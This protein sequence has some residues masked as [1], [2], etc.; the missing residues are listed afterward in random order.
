MT[1]TRASFVSTLF[2][3]S[4]SAFGADPKP[5]REPFNAAMAAKAAAYIGQCNGPGAEPKPRM[6]EFVD[7]L[8][9]NG[10][11]DAKVECGVSNFEKNSPM[12]MI[13]AA[14]GSEY[15]VNFKT[16]KGKTLWQTGEVILDAK[17]PEGMKRKVVWPPETAKKSK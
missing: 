5:A 6:S 9:A 8:W 16:A 2:V 7:Y 3:L 13:H 17:T 1:L 14:D 12:I 15:Y 11:K 10:L 4:S